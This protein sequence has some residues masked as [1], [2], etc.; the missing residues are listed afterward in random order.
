MSTDTIYI[1]IDES[2]DFGL[3]AKSNT[4]HF[5][6][7]ATYLIHHTASVPSY[8]LR[9]H[10]YRLALSDYKYDLIANH[11]INL[12]YFHASEDIEKVRNTVFDIIQSHR[13]EILGVSSLII[14]K[15]KL[16]GLY[17]SFLKRKKHPK[18]GKQ[19]WSTFLYSETES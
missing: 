1:F 15:Y 10:N 2:G 18:S 5:L 8:N 19:D 14:D 7:T 17:D 12:E 16:E 4:R 9:L 11:N 6:L 13:D 3:S